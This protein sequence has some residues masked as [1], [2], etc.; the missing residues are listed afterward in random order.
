MK[1]VMSNAAEVNFLS[2]SLYI[3]V[4]MI[5]YVSSSILLMKD[6]LGEIPRLQ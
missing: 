5:I 2:K 1:I 4:L 6:G 3:F